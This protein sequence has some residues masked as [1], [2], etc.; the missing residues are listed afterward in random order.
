MNDLLLSVVVPVYN[1]EAEVLKKCL[2]CFD[3][4]EASYEVLLVNDGSDEKT[5]AQLERYAGNK[6][7]VHLISQKNA[8]V[9]AARNHGI[10]QAQGRWI[11][12]CDADDT[13][14]V[15]KALHLI[16]SLHDMEYVCTSYVKIK[17]DQKET[18][19]LE[20]PEE[21]EALIRKILCVPNL[22]G[23]VWSKFYRRDLLDKHD[24]RFHTDLTHAEDTIFILEY[25]K[26]VNRIRYV[27]E[28]FYRYHVYENSSTKRNPK[29]IG[30]YL[31]SMKYVTDMY[32]NTPYESAAGNFCI[33]NLLV[34]LVHYVW[35]KG[36]GYREGKEMLDRLMKEPA[37]I[38]AF[39]VYDPGSLSGSSRIMAFLLKHHSDYLCY[40]ACRIRN[41][42]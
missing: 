39:A 40:T 13:M 24:V 8:G 7:W 1:P 3:Q 31:S 12:F 20:I 26:H 37:M 38:H 18:T 30:N 9:S 28:N 34:M 5:C 6:P 10:E 4:K 16:R 36:T 42:K 27:S 25:L 2:S 11:T 23:T 15:K 41:R 19:E 33:V 22:Y 14:D 21:R 35:K 17:G 32:Q 29:A